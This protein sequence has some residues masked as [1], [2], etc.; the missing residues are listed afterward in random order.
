M[1]SVVSEDG[2]ARRRLTAS[3]R[4]GMRELAVHLSL[5]NHQVGARLALKDTDIDCLDLITRH[6][7]L[8]PTALAKLAGLHPATLTGVLDRLEKGGW[9]ARERDPDD[10]RAVRVRGL[11]DRIGE[12]LGVY[13]G[14]TDEVEEVWAGHNA[15]EM[16]F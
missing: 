3:V 6:G 4:E 15:G 1:S 8:T 13:G 5:L 2:R 16:V 12:L 11:K 9:V 7:P 14:M 10:R